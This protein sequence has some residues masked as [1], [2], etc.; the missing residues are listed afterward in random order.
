MESSEAAKTDAEA[1]LTTANAYERS[2]Q[3]KEA[4]EAYLR[5]AKLS[6]APKVKLASQIGLADCYLAMHEEQ[7]GLSILSG[8]INHRPPVD[9]VMLGCLYLKRGTWYKKNGQWTLALDDFQQAM[10]HPGTKEAALFGMAETYHSLNKMRLAL[11]RISQVTWLDP[12]NI[13]A[14]RL[15]G[16]WWYQLSCW[17]QA[18]SD[19]SMV[20]KLGGPDVEMYARRGDCHR[21]LGDKVAALDDC[22]AAI[23]LNPREVIGY[24]IRARVYYDIGDDESAIS[25]LNKAIALSPK[26][27]RLH[28]QRAVVYDDMKEAALA[29]QDRQVAKSLSH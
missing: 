16:L 11:T 10:T 12:H 5:V 20:L 2:G 14:Y 7:K 19:F 25:D 29:A 24:R 13:K 9:A 6:P 27:R 26:D 18:K 3:F 8:L 17:S 1:A 22:T 4:I 15:R 21:Q 23:Q 28:L